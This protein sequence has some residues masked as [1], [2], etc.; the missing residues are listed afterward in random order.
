MVTDNPSELYII[1]NRD[2]K[3][4]G[5]MVELVN[6]NLSSSLSLPTYAV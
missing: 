4:A 1:S 5:Q 2:V 6:G 3:N